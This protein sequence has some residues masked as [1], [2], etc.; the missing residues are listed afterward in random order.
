MN[1]AYIFSNVDKFREES[2]MGMGTLSYKIK[3]EVQKIMKEKGVE[4]KDLADTFKEVGDELRDK[5]AR[6]ASIAK[7]LKTIEE[8][9]KKSKQSE[10]EDMELQMEIFELAIESGE[11]AEDLYNEAMKLYEKKLEQE[12]T[13][14]ILKNETFCKIVENIVKGINNM[15]LRLEEEFDSRLENR[16]KFGGSRPF[17]IA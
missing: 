4:K 6:L 11:D 15:I 17:Y 8:S 12:D 9:A 16:K 13:P 3:N 7:R 10:L 2:L 14:A 5:I 1:S